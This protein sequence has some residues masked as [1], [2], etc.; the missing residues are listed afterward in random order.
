MGLKVCGDL[1]LSDMSHEAVRKET[2]MATINRGM[3]VEGEKVI[4]LSYCSMFM[5]EEELMVVK[6][7]GVPV[8]ILEAR[9]SFR[10]SAD[11]LGPGL[12][13]WN[14]AH[15]CVNIVERV[16]KDKGTIPYSENLLNAPSFIFLSSSI[17][18]DAFTSLRPLAPVSYGPDF[19][20]VKGRT[21]VA[22]PSVLVP[23]LFATLEEYLNNG[24][25][26]LGRRQYLAFLGVYEMEVIPFE[27][28]STQVTLQ[29]RQIYYVEKGHRFVELFK[30]DMLWSECLNTCYFCFGYEVVEDTVLTRASV[31][32]PLLGRIRLILTDTQ[33]T[34]SVKAVT[35]ETFFPSE[36]QF[37][38]LISGYMIGPIRIPEDDVEREYLISLHLI[39]L[40]NR[41]PKGF[42]TKQIEVFLSRLGLFT[43]LGKMD[44][45]VLRRHVIMMEATY[46]TLAHSVQD[47]DGLWTEPYR[48]KDGESR[49]DPYED[50]EDEWD[51]TE[52]YREKPS[53][54]P[55]KLHF[56]VESEDEH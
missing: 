44:D 3:K 38:H 24:E 45:D 43:R 8:Y 26:F 40:M 19:K 23:V 17:Y 15:S 52:P 4:V 56:S 14:G 55:F 35:F 51:A 54:D 5:T 37:Y 32:F 20:G 48:V 47:I 39:H 2:I 50:D 7:K 16:I 28:D 12:F 49:D 30:H 34:R 27:G 11:H 18:H 53:D 6:S 41:F 36:E 13:G 25:R 21:N 1:N 46:P 10:M 9:D 31:E 22:E 29:T 33:D 42:M